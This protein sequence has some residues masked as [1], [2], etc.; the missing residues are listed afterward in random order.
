[1]NIADNIDFELDRLR[2]L[3]W[4]MDAIFTIPGTHVRIGLDTF[5]GFIPVV[6]DL[7]TA[8]PG[9]WMI[10][11]ARKLGA[12]PGTLAYMVLNTAFDTAIGMIP[13]VGDIFDMFYCANIRNYNALER[14]LNKKAAR[15]KTVRTAHKSV[16][17]VK[18]SLVN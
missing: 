2:T 11:Q 6:G 16:G 7:L 15:A 8:L 14:N 1:M 13:V 12:S 18:P 10:N 3:A 4:R 5:V 17:W 9:L